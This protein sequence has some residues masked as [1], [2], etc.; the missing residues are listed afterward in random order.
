M[1]LNKTGLQDSAKRRCFM[2]TKRVGYTTFSNTC[3]CF[4]LQIHSYNSMFL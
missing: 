1:L 3:D 2:S 4:A